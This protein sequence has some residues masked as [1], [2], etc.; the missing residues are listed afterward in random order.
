MTRDEPPPE[1]S[2]GARRRQAVGFLKNA[3]LLLPR[4]VQLLVRLMRDPRVSRADKLLVGALLTYV[5]TPVDIVPDFIPLA[6]Q[7][8]DLFAIALVLLRLVANSGERVLEEH[9]AGPPD[10]LPWI[11]RVA[12]FSRIFLPDRVARAV[13]DRFGN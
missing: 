6:G 8:D 1:T 9:W 5:A 13:A 4:I 10:L 3:I 12:Q 11:H 7:V 2:R